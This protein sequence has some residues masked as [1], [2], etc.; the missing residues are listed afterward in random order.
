MEE[1]AVGAYVLELKQIT[2]HTW[3]NVHKYLMNEIEHLLPFT[4]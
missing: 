2:I 3:N 1:Y 4:R